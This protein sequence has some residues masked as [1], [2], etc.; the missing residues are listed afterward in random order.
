MWPFQIPFGANL[1][2]SHYSLKHKLYLRLIGFPFIWSKGELVL[3]KVRP[4][5]GDLILDVGCGAGYYV[6]E[7]SVRGARVI[8]LD[9]D[10]ETIGR[11]V[12]AW[13]IQKYNPVFTVADARHLPFSDNVFDK[14]VILDCL[15]HI[16]ED[17]K[18]LSEVYRVLKDGGKLI[19][20]VPTIP[21]YPPHR[22]FTR[23]I[24][25]LPGKL[26]L[27]GKAKGEG[28]V[29]GKSDEEDSIQLARANET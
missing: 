3:D 15:E 17:G 8:G 12:P 2:E 4:S 10:R 22:V 29:L 23:L 5:V 1:Y 24:P 13:I 26:L 25:L 7:F 11:G 21:G 18:V 19:L 28:K 27:K 9:I 6:G 16:E 14:V 20:T